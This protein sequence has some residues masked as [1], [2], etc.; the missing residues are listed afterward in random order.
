MA[1]FEVVGVAS[2][3]PFMALV[4]DSNLIESNKFFYEIYKYLGFENHS[5]FIILTGLVVLSILCVASIFSIFTTWRASLFAMNTGNEISDRLFDFYMKQDWLFHTCGSSAQLTKQIT[6][7]SARVTHNILQPFM[8]LNSKLFLALFI[9]IGIVLYNPLMAALVVFIFLSGYFIIYNLVKK[10]LLKNG[11]RL[12]ETTTE[13]FRLINEGLGGIRDVLLLNRSIFYVEKF[14]DSGVAQARAQAVNNSL[15]QSPRYF[16]ELVAFGS[17]ILLVLILVNFYENSLSEVLPLL[18]V[19][20]LSGLKLLPALQQSYNSIAVIKGSIAAFEAIK[21]DLGSSRNI[22]SNNRDLLLDDFSN[23]NDF[24]AINFR[25][26]SFVY[27][28]AAGKAISD[29]SLSINLKSTVGFV[30]ESG[31]G[32]STLIDLIVGLIDPTSGYL[33]IDNKKVDFSNKKSWQKNIGFVSQNIFLNE[34]SIAENVAFGVDAAEINWVN[35]KKSLEMAQ[36][37]DLVERLPAGLN[38]K[39]GERGVKLS[40]GQK[41]RIGIARALYNDAKIL[42]FD[43]ATSALDGMTE[44]NIMDA[45]HNMKGQRTIIMI[46]HRL[47][48]VKECDSIFMIK[49][50]ILIDQGSYFDLISRNKEFKEMSKYS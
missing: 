13:R 43:E 19:Y 45:I 41:Q 48:T 18:T 40:G 3:G 47:K 25:D 8:I 16:M 10:K 33:E 42:V 26:V 30:G 36:L 7:E 22:Y 14:K 23:L 21:K 50:G 6:T 44:K 5:S 2:I 15:S 49:N 28:G 17:M 9:C 24:N 34:G 46:A 12:S 32:K 29:V 38:T 31:S 27:P 4:A 1:I 11:S 37:T 20:A 39:I 35:V